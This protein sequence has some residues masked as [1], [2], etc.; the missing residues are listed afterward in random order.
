MAARPSATPSARPKLPRPFVDPGAALQPPLSLDFFFFATA[1]SAYSSSSS[2]ELPEP[3]FEHLSL[4]T[5]QTGI[6]QHANFSVP[7]YT[8]GYCL[9]D[10]A[11]ALLP[12][13]TGVERRPR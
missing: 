7:S 11:R 4:L 9:D 13:S 10:N 12:L 2:P 6:L 1:A 3:N 8:D 5:D